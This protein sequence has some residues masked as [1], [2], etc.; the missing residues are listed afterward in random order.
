MAAS[1]SRDIKKWWTP[2]EDQQLL[3]LKAAGKANAVIAHALRRSTTSV[4]ARL[5]TLT[6]SVDGTRGSKRLTVNAHAEK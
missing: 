4:V 6:G 1:M 3:K 2:D 5:V